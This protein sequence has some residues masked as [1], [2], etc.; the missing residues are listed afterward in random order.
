MRLKAVYNLQVELY[1]LKTV[2][3]SMR[4]C[5]NLAFRYFSI[6]LW[7]IHCSFAD[8]LILSLL[9]QSVFSIACVSFM[10]CNRCFSLCQILTDAALLKRQKKEIE[11]LRAKLQVGLMFI[12]GLV[13]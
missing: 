13:I 8:I 5:F 7:H 1:A 6:F 2:L 4:L 12:S 3:M 9:G 10:N 11:E